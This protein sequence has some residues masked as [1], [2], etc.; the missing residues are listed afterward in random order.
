M[1]PPARSA[2]ALVIACG[3]MI[4][5]QS[6]TEQYA[7]AFGAIELTIGF[8]DQIMGL[9]HQPAGEFELLLDTHRLAGDYT[10][11]VIGGTVG[12]HNWVDTNI[13]IKSKSGPWLTQHN[14]VAF[15]TDSGFIL[16]FVSRDF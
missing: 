2:V 12:W 5:T 9:K 3:M 8:V 7:I 4:A 6:M 11:G 16:S 15:F 14:D 1:I 13:C 10:D